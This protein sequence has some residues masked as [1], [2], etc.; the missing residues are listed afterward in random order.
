MFVGEG[1]D[2]LD[3]GSLNQAMKSLVGLTEGNHLIGIISHFAEL[4]EKIDKQI[5]VTKEKAGLK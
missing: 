1:F 3:E 4:R 5:L 2:S